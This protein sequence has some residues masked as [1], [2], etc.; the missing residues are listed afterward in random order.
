MPLLNS[1]HQNRILLVSTQPL[2]VSLLYQPA[3]TVWRQTPS[4]V[5]GVARPHSIEF[6][7]CSRDKNQVEKDKN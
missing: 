1:R 2:L 6:R 7:Y 3:Y 5:S 4:Y